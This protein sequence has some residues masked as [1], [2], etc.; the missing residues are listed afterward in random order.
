MEIDYIRTNVPRELTGIFFT[1]GFKANA[2][3]VLIPFFPGIIVSDFMSP[4]I[5]L[6]GYLTASKSSHR[7]SG[8]EIAQLETVVIDNL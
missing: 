7:L 2:A 4:A 3:R 5:S 1:L 8:L 6:T